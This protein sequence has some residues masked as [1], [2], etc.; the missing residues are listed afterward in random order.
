MFESSFATFVVLE[1]FL[2]Q[3]V[4]LLEILASVTGFGMLKSA[5]F[6]SLS[7]ENCVI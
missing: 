3:V 5:R 1:Q 2:Y 4:L 7:R 6:P